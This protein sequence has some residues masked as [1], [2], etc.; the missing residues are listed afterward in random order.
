MAELNP[1]I[2]GDSPLTQMRLISTRIDYDGMPITITKVREAAVAMAA[3]TPP[4]ES[5]SGGVWTKT[6][7]EPISDLLVW[8]ITETRAVPGLYVPRTQDDLLLG[9][10]TGTRRLVE[11]SGLTTLKT[12]TY[13][14]TY[15]AHENS[16]VVCWELIETNSDGTGSAD[17]P[18]YPIRIEDDY[19]ND[20]GPIEK[21][22]QVV[23]ATGSEVG[24]LDAGSTLQTL[25][26]NNAG[27]GY[28]AGEIITLAGGTATTAATVRVL[29]VSS[30][31]IVTFSVEDRGLYSATSASLTQASTS[32]SGTAATFQS[33]TYA[34]QARL[35]SYKPIDQFKLDR[36]TELWTLPG[37]SVV[38]AETDADGVVV[39]VTRTL[40]LKS[41]I[42]ESDT[43][44]GGTTWTLVKSEPYSGNASAIQWEVVR[45][46]AV[47][48]TAKPSTRIDDDGAT[49]TITRTLKEA[50]TITASETANG[51]TWTLVRKDD[52]PQSA[53][54]A[55]EVSESRPLKADSSCPIIRED[56]WNDQFGVVEAHF[57]QY[58]P[59]GTT[60]PVI[61][62]S[63]STADTYVSNSITALT[64]D[65]PGSGY[66][67]IP[68]LTVSA[69][70]GGGTQATAT[71]TNLQAVSATVSEPGTGYAFGDTVQGSTGTGTKAT[72]T[73][74]GGKLAA[75]ALNA[76]GTLYATGDTITLAGGTFSTAASLTVATT[77]IVAVVLSG[78]GTGMVAGTTVLTMT[79]GTFSSAATLLVTNT[80]VVSAT[81]QTI[82]AAADGTY[83]VTGTTGTT[84]PAA[85]YFQASVT[86]SAG[87]TVAVVN[88]ITVAGNYT[89]NPTNIAAEPVT[90]TPV[91]LVLTVVMGVHSSSGATITSGGSYTVPPLIALPYTASGGGGDSAWRQLS[92]INTFTITAPGQYSYPAVTTFT[93]GSTSG[94]GTGATF[95]A[96]TY[97]INQLTVLTGGAYTVIATNPDAMATITGAGSGMTAVLDFGIGAVAIGNAGTLYYYAPT[98]TPN[99]GGAVI[100]PTMSAPVIMPGSPAGY[101]VSTNLLNTEHALIKRMTW[102][103]MTTPP[104]RIERASRSFAFP[105][106]FTYITA[107]TET[108]TG[109]LLQT[110]PFPGVNYTQTQHGSATKPARCTISYSLGPS[111]SV[112]A[113]WSVITPGTASR[114]FPIGANTIHNSWTLIES[115][116]T[117]SQTVEKIDASTPAS[118]TKGQT[119]VI[120]AEERKVAGNFYEK[121]IY[122]ITE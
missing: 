84:S 72:F 64:V 77:K 96:A 27:S 8:K 112:P 58:V 45:T 119:L 62:A 73:V 106:V 81:V 89:A 116:S 3:A 90:G 79:G 82:G 117:A 15:D 34:T 55:Y 14:R 24:N 98:I 11:N 51:T 87:G 10:I 5:V 59:G 95:Q 4:N 46:R 22:T 76:A 70:P 94:S 109:G 26:I 54:V 92:G 108:P 2:T 25:A 114:N 30:G 97:T 48:G 69:S 63:Y 122:T 57:F 38:G 44:A 20:R 9:P 110:G 113:T 53:A 102:T 13:S 99:Y 88:S 21:R 1:N 39:T 74:T 105:T 104:T 18:A 16:K 100:T 78:A 103:T 85:T 75:L 121:R 83:T 91:G 7:Q 86:Y 107:W 68:T 93:A 56:R 65:D 80:K 29:T 37:P 61:G 50:S 42:T 28:V 101:V 47:P 35:I 111:G 41:A 67:T 19:E 23:V 49:V 12:A 120:A 43:V 32:G 71:V 52:H 115:N 33:A 17:N 40:K 31:A 66:T 118:Y 36:T 60:K 6:Y